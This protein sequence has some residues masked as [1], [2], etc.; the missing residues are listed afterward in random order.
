MTVRRY[1]ISSNLPAVTLRE[2]RSDRVRRGDS[3]WR[4]LQ[5]EIQHGNGIVGNPARGDVG[6]VTNRHSLQEYVHKNRYREV[7]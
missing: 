6:G 1:S 7:L 4:R 3:G 2:G 5:E